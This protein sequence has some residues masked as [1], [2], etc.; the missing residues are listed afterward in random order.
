MS[1]AQIERESPAVTLPIESCSPGETDN[2]GRN[3]I[4]MRQCHTIRY[5][6]RSCTYRMVA[7]CPGV[8]NAG[9]VRHFTSWQVVRDDYGHDR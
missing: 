7:C 3:P 1:A 8:G 9:W 4:E 2:A 6:A 5:N